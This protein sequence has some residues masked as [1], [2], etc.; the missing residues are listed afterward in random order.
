MTK[1]ILKKKICIVVSSPSTVEAFLVDQVKALCKRYHVSIVANTDDLDRLKGIGINIEITHV[2]IKRKISLSK[3]LIALS[4]LYSIFKKYRFDI[5]HSVTPKAGLLCMTA[6]ALAGVRIR[7]HTFTGQVWATKKGHMRRLLK[8]SDRII[9]WLSTNLLVDSASQKDFLLSEKVVTNGKSMVLANGSISGVDTARFRPHAAVRELVRSRYGLVDTDVVF[10]FI[11]RLNRDKGLL[12]LSK[13][14]ELAYR[15]CSSVYLFIVGRD[16]ENIEGYIKDHC[17]SCLNRIVFVDYTTAP[18]E[19]MAAADVLCLPSHREG[20]GSV[21]IEAAAAGVPSIGSKI[22]GIID[23][24]EANVTGLLFSA[25]NVDE[26][27]KQMTL[28]ATNPNLREKLGRNALRRARQLFAKELVTSA[29][30]SHY[31][32]LLSAEK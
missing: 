31:Q 6:G 11:G 16:E 2:P 7:I 5:V 23:A 19:F 30:L 28:L 29:L 12:E 13:A 15:K 20:F 14:F 32:M 27:N 10:L 24:V 3:D 18:H 8:F 26:L 21:I 1:E 4:I 22:Y 17:V 9:S 25:G